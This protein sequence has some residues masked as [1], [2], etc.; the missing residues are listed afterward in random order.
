MHR[1]MKNYTR[2]GGKRSNLKSTWKKQVNVHIKCLGLSKHI[3]D[4]NSKWKNRLDEI[5]V[6]SFW[7]RKISQ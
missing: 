5:K 1:G 7:M 4:R 3:K 6:R 2:K